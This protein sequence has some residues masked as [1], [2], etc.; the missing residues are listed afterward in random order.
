[1]PRESQNG[2]REIENSFAKKK[3]EFKNIVLKTL[4]M[5]SL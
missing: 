5:K 2:D 1:L 4:S 3:R